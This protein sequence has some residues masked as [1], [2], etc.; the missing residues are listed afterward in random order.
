MCSPVAAQ[1]LVASPARVSVT[2]PPVVDVG[3]EVVVSLGLSLRV[4]PRRRG[5]TVDLRRSRGEVD[6]RAL[7]E[8]LADGGTQKKAYSST[9][10]KLALSLPCGAVDDRDHVALVAGNRCLL[11]Q[12]AEV[13]H[14]VLVDGDDEDA[15]GLEQALGQPQALLHH[16]QPLGVPPGVVCDRRSRCC[17]SSRARR[18]CRA[19]RCRCSR[20]GRSQQCTIAAGRGSSRR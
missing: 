12:H 4:S 11:Q 20:P 13:V 18:C 7:D 14:L 2:K 5:R 16:R 1:A 19:D 17:T 15:V 9:R 10:E 8:V 3:D 6:G